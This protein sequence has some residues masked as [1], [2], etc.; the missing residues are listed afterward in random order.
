MS[1]KHPE[2]L[3]LPVKRPSVLSTERKGRQCGSKE[4]YL[5][6]NH[7]KIESVR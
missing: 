5:R 3:E 7:C 1:L 4:A 6:A 2:M